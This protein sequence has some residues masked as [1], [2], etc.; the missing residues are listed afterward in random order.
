MQ[1]AASSIITGV[2]RLEIN[3]TS[4]FGILR[5]IF[6]PHTF[7]SVWGGGWEQGKE[8]SEESGEHLTL[9]VQKVGG[10]R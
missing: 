4:R 1:E 3:Q 2:G 6:P 5:C 9:S 8:G 10:L 7:L